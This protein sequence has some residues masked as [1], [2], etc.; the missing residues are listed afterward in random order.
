[1][2]RSNFCNR[3]CVNIFF[4]I[5]MSQ[6]IEDTLFNSVRFAIFAGCQRVIIFCMYFR[7]RVALPEKSSTINVYCI[8]YLVAAVS[9][10]VFAISI[11]TVYTNTSPD[12][13]FG[14]ANYI[15]VI[16]AI[17]I[18]IA[19]SHLTPSLTN[20]R[21]PLDVPYV[22]KRFGDMMLICI[23]EISF[24]LTQCAPFS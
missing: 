2:L 16:P 4:V 24:A 21:L 6:H 18:L 14:P 13:Y 7:C 11:G 5:L 22:I 20:R 12:A 9:Y 15:A 23:G 3:Y 1:M 8:Q 19:F 17:E 10:F